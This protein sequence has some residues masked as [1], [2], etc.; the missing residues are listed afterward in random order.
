LRTRTKICGI[1]RL[2]DA[3]AAASAGTDAIGFVF[4][5]KSPRYIAPEAARAIIE[6]LPVFVT[7]VGLFVDESTSYVQ[8]V[9]AEAPVDVLQFHGKEP[10]AA[11]IKYNKPYMKAIPMAPDIDLVGAISQY[12]KSA[13]ILLDTYDVTLPGGTGRVFNWSDVP[14]DCQKPIVLA[15]GLNPGNIK[16]AIQ[17]TSPWAVDVSGGVEAD[18]GIKNPELIEAFIKGV[19][20]A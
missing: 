3:L 1:T 13:A 11:C 8:S 7:T 10:E 9:L 16:E 12:P 4:Y 20:C 19:N 18:K 14:Q 17:L 2:S 15:G 5:K 6:A